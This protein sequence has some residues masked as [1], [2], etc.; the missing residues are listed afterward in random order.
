MTE[1]LWFLGLVFVWPIAALIW[2]AEVAALV[3]I[4][5]AL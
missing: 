4:P 5:L 2:V 3:G 1:W